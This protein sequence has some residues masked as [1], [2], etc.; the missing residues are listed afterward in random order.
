MRG[1]GLAL[2]VVLGIVA[3]VGAQPRPVALDDVPPLTLPPV[4]AEPAGLPNGTTVSQPL[5]E[6][7]PE[8]TVASVTPR[9]GTS[10]GPI[11]RSW[12][13]GEVLIWWPQSQRLPPLLVST[14]AGGTAVD[15]PN[16]ILLVGPRKTD[17]P[18]GA[19]GRFVLGWSLGPAQRT[20]MEVSYLFT[21]TQSSLDRNAP[22]PFETTA[23][24]RI[25][26]WGVTGVANL[27]AG[28]NATVNALA[29]YRY[30]MVNE[31][32]RFE[33]SSAFQGIDTS[34]RTASADQFDA[35]NRFHG[36]EL[37]LRTEFHRGP[38]SLQFDT[39]VALG[40]T[41]EVVRVSGQTVAVTKGPA[42]VST[43]WF[44]SGLLGPSSPGSR[45]AQSNFAVLPE[46]GLKFGYQL[47][48]RARFSLG[49]SVIYLSDAVRPGDQVDGNP[50]PFVRSDFWVQGV[51]LGMEW[52]Y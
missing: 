5:Q 48:A 30:F 43:Q 47:G 40:R 46:G 1:M 44:P 21:G 26:S 45:T 6:P 32:L 16:T 8:A 3:G 33:Q 14:S 17:P 39:K 24:S 22:A 36:A 29:G 35:H 41:V 20:G 49:Y 52:R 12:Y 19:G 4:S 2:L 18:A 23:S 10:L 15:G 25:Q 28:E 50:A 38:F 31:G 13:S 42:G 7:F 37:G 11:P 34:F 51:T 27:Y 9:P